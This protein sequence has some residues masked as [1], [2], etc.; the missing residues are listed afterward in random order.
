MPLTVYADLK[1]LAIGTP[2]GEFTIECSPLAY[3]D[4]FNREKYIAGIGRR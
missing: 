1:I 3:R 4:V 2:T